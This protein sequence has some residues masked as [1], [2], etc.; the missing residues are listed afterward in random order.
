[1]Y[2]YYTLTGDKTPLKK[3]EK[4]FSTETHQGTLRAKARAGRFEAAKTR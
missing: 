1:M 2:S 4:T 3:E